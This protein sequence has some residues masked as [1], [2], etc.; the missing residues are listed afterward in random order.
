MK[1]IDSFA[2]LERFCSQYE[3]MTEAAAALDITKQYLSDI[4]RN[5]RDITPRVLGKL[6]L[7]RVVVKDQAAQ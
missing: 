1:H 4:L 7:K 3:T 5:R 6:G 2:A